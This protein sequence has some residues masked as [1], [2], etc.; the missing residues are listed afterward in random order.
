MARC[1]IPAGLLIGALASMPALGQSAAVPGVSRG[2][3][4]YST[5]CIACHSTQMHWRD[6]RIARDWPGLKAEVRRWQAAA[7]LAWGDEDI[8]EVARHL[9]ALYYGFVEP[10][11]RKAGPGDLA[12]RGL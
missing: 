12:A 6:A 5:H 3:L 7:R 9:N 10:Q 1:W 4:L 2:S 8:T 11:A